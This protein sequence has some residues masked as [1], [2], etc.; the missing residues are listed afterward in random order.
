MDV[1]MSKWVGECA[2]VRVTIKNLQED[3]CA[4]IS[5][6]FSGHKTALHEQ[7]IYP[8]MAGLH[9]LAPGETWVK[10]MEVYGA[11]RDDWCSYKVFAASVGSQ[12]WS[13]HRK[14]VKL[15]RPG[16]K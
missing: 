10:S 9:S 7:F 5:L 8:L 12:T 4:H 6:K 1:K 11:R 16:D 2:R 15:S 14:S 3:D 13:M